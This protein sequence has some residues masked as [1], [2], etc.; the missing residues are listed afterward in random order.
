MDLKKLIANETSPDSNEA[1]SYIKQLASLYNKTLSRVDTSVIK[2]TDQFDQ[3]NIL[4]PF[5]EK[6]MI[7]IKNAFAYMSQLQ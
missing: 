5:T 4:N 6:E 2:S 1:L 3:P 7:F